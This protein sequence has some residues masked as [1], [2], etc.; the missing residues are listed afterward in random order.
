M[1][2]TLAL[3]LALALWAAPFVSLSHAQPVL[4]GPGGLINSSGASVTITNSTTATSIYSYTVPGGL[5]QGNFNPLHLKLIG[6]VTTNPS[7]GGVGNINVGCNFGG[8]TASVALVN[9]AALDANMTSTPIEIDVWLSGYT[10][11]Q[12]N[13]IKEY[14][15]ARMNYQS[16]TAQTPKQFAA[17]VAGTTALSAQTIT[18][19]WQWASAATTNSLIIHNGTLRQGS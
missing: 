9:A 4:V 15:Q 16:A 6:L 2:R 3:A 1:R 8:T 7:S 18:C 14:L 10:A 19:V 5:V 13:G 12:S 17:G 11:A